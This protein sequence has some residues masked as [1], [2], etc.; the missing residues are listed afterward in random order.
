MPPG[1]PLALPHVP[2]EQDPANRR[3]RSWSASGLAAETTRS[4]MRLAQFRVDVTVLLGA[5]EG[6][7][8]G[9]AELAARQPG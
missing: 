5:V 1:R 7:G 2:G 6:E 4:L 9:R 3:R 8:E